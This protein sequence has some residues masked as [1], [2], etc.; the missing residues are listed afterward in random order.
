MTWSDIGIALWP[1]LIFALLWIGLR[2]FNK[3]DRKPRPGE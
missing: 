1:V 2:Q 3:Q